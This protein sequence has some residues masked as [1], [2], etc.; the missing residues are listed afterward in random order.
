MNF[1]DDHDTAEELSKL[2]LDTIMRATPPL[3]PERFASVESLQTLHRSLL[4]LRAYLYAAA[5][6]DLSGTIALKGYIGGALKTLQANL[7]HMI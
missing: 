2:L 4:S 3:L 7:K 1:Q 5:N 6:G